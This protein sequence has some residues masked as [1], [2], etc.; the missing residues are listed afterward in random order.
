MEIY[1]QVFENNA[2]W[3]ALKTGAD[4]EYFQRLSVEQ[5]PEFLYIGCSD[6]RVHPNNFLVLD[7]G[8]V[9]MYKNIAN[10][11]VPEELGIKSVVY[12]A[13]V[14]LNVKYIVVC[15]HYRCGGIKAALS[16][17]SFG[18][19]DPWLKRI[20][21]VAH[22]HESELVH[23]VDFNERW[24]KMVEWNVMEQCRQVELLLD[25]ADFNELK[26]RPSVHGWVYDLK[27]GLLKD[28][29]YPG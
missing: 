25:C 11:V 3:A 12:F 29:K 28:M 20:K 8:H 5:N 18:C 7:P 17:E 1:N 26:I 27:H 13:A 14:H 23:I 10:Q 21:D 22:S 6:S 4:P 9:F 2:H 16:E 15:G 19:M 24:D